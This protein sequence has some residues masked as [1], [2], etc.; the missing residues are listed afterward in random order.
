MAA[1]F[2]LEPFK[3]PLLFLG[4]AGVVVPLFRR[5]RVSPVL[6]FLVAGMLIGPNVLGRI[7][8][9][10]PFDLPVMANSKNIDVI[11]E[12]GV[13]F[14]MFN[15]GLELS[16]ERLLLLRRFVFGLGAL[17]V[18]V[19]GAALFGVGALVG[20]SQPARSCSA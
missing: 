11:A 13:V 5:L 9:I 14:L 12:F 8:R 17:Q 6:G 2:D 1:H 7:D 18:S 16:L 3:A 19:C 20:L 10:V 15:I 4:V